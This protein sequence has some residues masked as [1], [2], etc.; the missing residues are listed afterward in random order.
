[1]DIATA[2]KVF[3]GGGLKKSRIGV[4]TQRLLMWVIWF[5]CNPLNGEWMFANVLTLNSNVK[6]VLEAIVA[7]MD[8]HVPDIDSVPKLPKGNNDVQMCTCVLFYVLFKTTWSSEQNGPAMLASLIR[9]AAA[10][11]SARGLSHF[12]E[13]SGLGL[14]VRCLFATS[15]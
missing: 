15:Q 13:W 11:S 6:V 2:K 3:S 14:E 10:E 12:T 5:L 4:E 7:W 8:L 1:V 9:F